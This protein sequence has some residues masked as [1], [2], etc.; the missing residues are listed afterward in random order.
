MPS[1]GLTLE[2]SITERALFGSAKRE[3]L[4]MM[5][6]RTV[7]LIGEHLV[8]YLAEAARQL[9]TECQVGRVVLL[10]RTAEGSAAMRAALRDIPPDLLHTAVIGDDI[11]GGIDAALT[12]HG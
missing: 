1:D 6:A 7:W 2:R 4:D 8:E 12:R 5:R 3:R 10:T 9:V 11:E